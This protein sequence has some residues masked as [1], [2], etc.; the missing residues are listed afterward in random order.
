MSHARQALALGPASPQALGYLAD[1]LA[2]S[3]NLDEA[4]T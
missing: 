4:V 1:A 3:G 2:V